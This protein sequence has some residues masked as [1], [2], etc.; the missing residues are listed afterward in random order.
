[1]IGPDAKHFAIVF[2]PGAP[3]GE[4]D[5]QQ[6]RSETSLWAKTMNAAGRRLQPHM[7]NGD[8]RVLG[9]REAMGSSPSAVLFLLARDLEDAVEVARQHPALRFGYCAEVRSWANPAGT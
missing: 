8:V 5:T 6:M 1:M 4:E 7:F 2:F 3:L 9:N